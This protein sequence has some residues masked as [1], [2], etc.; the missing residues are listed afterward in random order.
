MALKDAASRRTKSIGKRM[1]NAFD[2]N[3]SVTSDKLI[4]SYEKIHVKF[5]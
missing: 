4:L 2:T 5:E 3:T 1:G